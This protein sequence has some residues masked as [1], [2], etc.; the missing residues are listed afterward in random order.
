MNMA[1]KRRS[2]PKSANKIKY[3]FR[4]KDNIIFEDNSSPNV[5]FRLISDPK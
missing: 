5:I 4:P 3:Q 1:K 2:Y